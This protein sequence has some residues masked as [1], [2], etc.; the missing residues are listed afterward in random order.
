MLPV[1]IEYTLDFHPDVPDRVG[2]IGY[3]RLFFLK[4]NSLEP[5]GSILDTSRIM[6]CKGVMR[7]KWTQLCVVF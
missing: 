4:C 6:D 1:N 2:A 7:K 3:S 5:L